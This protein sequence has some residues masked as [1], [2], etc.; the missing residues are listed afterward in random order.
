MAR[1]DTKNEAAVWAMWLATKQRRTIDMLELMH[2]DVVWVPAVSTG[3][4]EYR[5]H[6]GIRQMNKDMQ[7]ARG[8]Y[9]VRLTEVAETEPDVVVARG[10]LVA[11]GADL[12]IPVEFTAEFRA[13][14]ISRVV[15]RI[16]PQP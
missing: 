15:A 10:N 12:G 1:S 8:D 11:D 6:D 16:E 13:G 3:T 7:A 14:K 9:T 4:P 5:G 2:P